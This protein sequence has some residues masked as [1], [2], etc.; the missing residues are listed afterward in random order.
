MRIRGREAKYAVEG[1]PSLCEL[2][3]DGW[4]ILVGCKKYRRG[5]LR[6]G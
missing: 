1:S 4:W 3:G 6:Q 2:T 5:G